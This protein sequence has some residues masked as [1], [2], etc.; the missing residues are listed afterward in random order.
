MSTRYKI[1][2]LAATLIS[3]IVIGRLTTAEKVIVQWRDAPPINGEIKQP[4]PVTVRVPDSIKYMTVYH[5]TRSCPT[6]SFDGDILALDSIS[7]GYVIGTWS[8]RID[9]AES[10]AATVQDWNLERTYS[11]MLFHS[12]TLGTLNYS[13]KV[14]YNTLTSLAWDYMPKIKSITTTKTPAF[15]PFV[16]VRANTFEQM[17]V[18]GGILLKNT[19]FEASYIKDFKAQKNGLGIGFIVCF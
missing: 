4:E 3:G 2:I 11:G 1:I 6:D 5:E 16:T 8:G 17:S 10:W 14:Q 9:T 7:R 19:G 15:R 18:G 13:A 12:D